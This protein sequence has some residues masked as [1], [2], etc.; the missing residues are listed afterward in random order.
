MKNKKYP[1]SI[2]ENKICI[3]GYYCTIQEVEQLIEDIQ[4]LDP[5]I[6]IKYFE[7]QIVNEKEKMNVIKIL[8]DLLNKLKMKNNNTNHDH[9]NDKEKENEL[10]RYRY[11]SGYWDHSYYQETNSQ[12]IP[13]PSSSTSSKTM[14]IYTCKKEII[15]YKRP[16][17]E[18]QIN[19]TT[20]TF[21]PKQ[22]EKVEK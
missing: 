21:N 8:H 5:P 2:L 18:P 11:G 4:D 19:I 15:A 20:A 3:D 13:T 22:P 6:T 9:N 10:M 12:T 1:I 16:L 14:P 7:H 17:T